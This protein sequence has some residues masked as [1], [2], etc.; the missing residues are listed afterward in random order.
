MINRFALSCLCIEL[1]RDEMYGVTLFYILLLD[2]IPYL[3]EV[4]CVYDR[5]FLLCSKMARKILSQSSQMATNKSTLLLPA[6]VLRKAIRVHDAPFSSRGL[7]P[8][9]CAQ[10]VVT[11]R[12]NISS[13]NSWKD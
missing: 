13:D 8:D 9:N 1:D 4:K 3:T 10:S 2:H 11:E 5:V 12:L 6:S 7:F